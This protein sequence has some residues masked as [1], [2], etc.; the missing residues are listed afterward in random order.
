MI[1]SEAQI[2]AER[3]AL[4]VRAPDLGTIAASGPE[5]ATWLNG[6]VTSDLTEL[7]PGTASYG[8]VLVKIRAHFGRCRGG[9]RG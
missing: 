2:A 4:L 1:L 8:L 3:G 7:G 5:R 6:L 9:A